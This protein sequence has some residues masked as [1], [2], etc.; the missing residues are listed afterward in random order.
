MKN[1]GYVAVSHL[2]ANKKPENYAAAMRHF[3]TVMF[4]NMT[5]GRT[6]EISMYGN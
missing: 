5:E 2:L 1:S 6:N 4:C 3:C